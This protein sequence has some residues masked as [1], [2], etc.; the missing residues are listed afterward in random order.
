MSIARSRMPR[1]PCGGPQARPAGARGR[2]RAPSGR[3]A[4]LRARGGGRTCAAL[5]VPGDVRQRLLG[6][7]IDDQ[8]LLLRQRQRGA[9]GA[10]R[11]G[12]CACSPNDVASAASALCSPRSSSASGRSRRA[13]RRTSSVPWRAVSRSSS[14]WS[15]ELLRDR[16]GQALDLE[17]HAGQRLADLVVELARDPLPLALLHE[18]R[19]ARALAPLGLQ[20]VEH[21]VERL[22][23][24]DDGRAAVDRT[25]S[26]GESGSCPRIVSASSSSGR[27]AGRR[28]ARLSASRHTRPAAST[29]SSIVAGG[30]RHG[31]RREDQGQERQHQ[32]RRVGAE[33]PP[34]QRQRVQS[35]T[36]GSSS[37]ATRVS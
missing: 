6:D 11:S 18:Q 33:H 7:A 28:S 35:R 15:R 25:R 24:R 17:H 21:L 30:H 31:D 36:H 37:Q 27:N 22:R 14:S 2:R 26:P 29:T 12:A 19:A 1:M 8:L 20:A 34:E 23:E 32:D 4:R 5:R 9:P 13:I 3:R 16:R 10:A